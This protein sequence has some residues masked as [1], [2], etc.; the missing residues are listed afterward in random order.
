MH[1][2]SLLARAAALFGDAPAVTCAGRTLDYVETHRRV[3]SL[4]AHLQARGVRAG[5]RVAVLDENRR[6]LFELYFAAAAIGAILA[7]INYRLSAPET[8]AIVA[9]AAPRLLCARRAFADQVDASPAPVVWI[10]DEF[11]AVTARNDTPQGVVPAADDTAHLYYTSGTTGRAKGVQLTHGN[12]TTHALAAIAE[13][14]L[15]DADVWGHYAPMFHLADAWATFAI[16]WVGGH[17]VLHPR[18]DAGE[19]LRSMATHRVTVTNLVPTMLGAMLAHPSLATADTG[20]LR[21]LLS[22]GA[23]IA[24][25]TVHRLV[26][27]FGCEYVQTYGMTETSPYLTLSRPPHHLRHLAAE[28]QLAYRCKT[29]RPFLTVELRVVDEQGNPVAADERSVGEI[30]VKGPTVT[31]GYWQDRDATAAAFDENGFLHTG[32]LAVIDADGFLTIVDRA[33]DVIITGGENVYS[34]EVENVLYQHAAI[35]EAAVFGIPDDEWGERVCAAVALRPDHSAD[36]AALD[37]HCRQRL[38]GFKVPRRYR[39]VAQLP[40]TGSG[41]IDKRALR[42][43][44]TP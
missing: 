38:A 9:H 32:D 15:C 8:R 4:A 5:D 43:A 33:K 40:R 3:L 44:A 1:L 14:G 10:D 16:T 39:Y 24:P 21:L 11:P 18:F 7:P 26:E 31:P 28:R 29:G 17:H 6:E 37:A 30:R 25:E 2:Y 27:A 35:L 20:S 13:L 42:A 22:G 34:I 23:A 41:K 36:D 19:V 12:V